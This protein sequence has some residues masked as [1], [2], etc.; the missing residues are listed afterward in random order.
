MGWTAIRRWRYAHWDEPQEEG[1]EVQAEAPSPEGTPLPDDF[2]AR[3]L[4]VEAGYTTLERVREATDEE[5]LAIRGVGRR[6]LE[7]IRDALR[8][9]G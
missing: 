7:R 4:L 5:L 2:P 8:H 1:A 3:A 9:A 6:L